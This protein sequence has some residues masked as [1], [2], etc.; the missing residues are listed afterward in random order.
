MQGI[1][2]LFEEYKSKGALHSRST[3]VE[4]QPRGDKEFHAVDHHHNLLTFY[5]EI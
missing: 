5:E 1:E 2:E 4:K 3:K